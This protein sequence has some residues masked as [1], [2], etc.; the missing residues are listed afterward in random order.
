MGKSV[1]RRENLRIPLAMCKNQSYCLVLKNSPDVAEKG[2]YSH[3][4]KMDKAG[5]LDGFEL[6][7]KRSTAGEDEPCFCKQI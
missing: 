1:E 4:D 3:D 5:D 7:D 6:H 2:G